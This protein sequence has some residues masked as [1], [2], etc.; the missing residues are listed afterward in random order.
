MIQH[1]QNQAAASQQA[2][3]HLVTPRPVL[4]QG[5]RQVS[6]GPAI[7]MKPASP[8]PPAMAAAAAAAAAAQNSATPLAAGLPPPA[9]RV[10]SQQGNNPGSAR[11]PSPIS[12]LILA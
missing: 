11:V 4:A 5:M 1:L 3:A 7:V 10:T 9:I 2:A 8:I 12:E 6:Q